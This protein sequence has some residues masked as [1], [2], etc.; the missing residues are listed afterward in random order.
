MTDKYKSKILLSM[1]QTRKKAATFFVVGNFSSYSQLFLPCRVVEKNHALRNWT[2]CKPD[3]KTISPS[4][5]S[6]AS[7]MDPQHLKV[8]NT[9]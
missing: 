7:A 2:D 5:L 4:T 1:N 6:S 8:K 9:N 3:N